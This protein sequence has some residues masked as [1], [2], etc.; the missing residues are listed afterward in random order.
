MFRERFIHIHRLH[1]FSPRTS[2][3]FVFLKDDD[4][5][6]S[7][8]NRRRSRTEGGHEQEVAAAS[9]AIL[10]PIAINPFPS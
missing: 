1:G 9:P 2:V 10:C 6:N 5:L 7:L 8:S 3:Q 4:E